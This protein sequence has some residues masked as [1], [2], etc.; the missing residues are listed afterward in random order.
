MGQILIAGAGQNPARQAAVEAGV[1]YDKTAYQINQLCGSGLRAVALGSQAVHL[2]DARVV[3]CGGQESMSQAPHVAHLRNGHKMGDFSM[4]DSM[5]TDG[6]RDAF[7]GYNM[8]NT[9]DNVAK[10]WQITRQEHDVFSTCRAR[11]SPDH[12]KKKNTT[13]HH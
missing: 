12:K 3:V 6:L 7:N 9:A 5:I 2:G 1:P 4:I 10:Q 11:W 13:K 8:G